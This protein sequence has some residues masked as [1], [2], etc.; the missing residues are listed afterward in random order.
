MTGLALQV[1][2]STRQSRLRYPAK[3]RKAALAALL[4]N[5]PTSFPRVLHT[6]RAPFGCARTIQAARLSPIALSRRQ[7]R[8]SQSLLPGRRRSTS[9]R[10][11]PRKMT[12]IYEEEREQASL[13]STN[14]RRCVVQ[15]TCSMYITPCRIDIPHPVDAYDD[16]LKKST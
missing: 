6:I 15:H 12:S 1:S 9:S 2:I 10:L 7:A 11:E 5:P 13:E 8:S 14:E 3:A 4:F 16:N